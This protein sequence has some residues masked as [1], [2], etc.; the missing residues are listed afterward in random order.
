MPTQ[1]GLPSAFGQTFSPCSWPAFSCK[2][3]EGGCSA[4]PRAQTRRKGCEMGRES[5]GQEDHIKCA[6]VGFVHVLP[7]PV[8]RI[9]TRQAR[10]GYFPAQQ[11]S[12]AAQKVYQGAMLGFG[13]LS[14]NSQTAGN[15]VQRAVC[16]HRSALW[17]MR[18]TLRQQIWPR[19][20]MRVMCAQP[21]LPKY[22]AQRSRLLGDPRQTYLLVCSSCWHTRPQN[23]APHFF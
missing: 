7:K 3:L 6:S 9:A 2:G 13:P 18:G 11:T 12:F 21:A 17:H 14:S 8:D 1:T 4:E 20:S 19:C 5:G 22:T 15:L 23:S 10:D 16:V